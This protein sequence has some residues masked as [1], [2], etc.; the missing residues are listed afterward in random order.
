MATAAE[1]AAAAAARAAEEAKCIATSAFGFQHPYSYCVKPTK[2]MV[3]AFTGDGWTME[4]TKSALKGIGDYIDFLTAKATSGSKDKCKDNS[5][6][7]LIGNKYVLK[8][9]IKCNIV[10]PYTGDISGTGYIHKYIDNTT[11]LGALLTGG[12]PQDDA[13]GLIPSTFASAGKI[14]SNVMGVVSA[15]SAESKPYCMAVRMNCHVINSQEQEKSYKGQ[16]P[17]VY[18]SIEDIKNTDASSFVNKPIIPTLPKRAGFA[19]LIDNIIN[20]NTD[21]I[22][23]GSEFENVLNSINFQDE[24]LVKTYY[25]GFLILL[26]IVVFKLINKNKLVTNL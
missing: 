13:N 11:T 18:M 1:L 15:F 5:A 23:G 2:D 26:I 12:E 14:G 21:K 6:N 17:E 22:Q 16:S 8:T 20:E 4:N 24:I 7:G 3:P 9:N 19:N 10:L 25:I